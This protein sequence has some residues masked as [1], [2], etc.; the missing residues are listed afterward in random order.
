M[1]DTFDKD[2]VNPMDLQF[3]SNKELGRAFGEYL[4]EVSSA[5][6]QLYDNQKSYLIYDKGNPQFISSDN[7]TL[8]LNGPQDSIITINGALSMT[9]NL[10]VLSLNKK[11]NCWEYPFAEKGWG[12]ATEDNS[13]WLLAGEMGRG[14]ATEDN[15]MGWYYLIKARGRGRD[16]RPVD[17]RDVW[18]VKGC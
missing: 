6:V 8:L 12:L 11:K 10:K 16:M 3:D 15:S 18:F 4:I 1:G 2:S 7:N 13:S 17:S 9:V 14:L 5:T